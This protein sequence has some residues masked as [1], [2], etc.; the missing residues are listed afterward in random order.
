MAKHKVKGKTM[1]MQKL[2]LRLTRTQLFDRLVE[3]IGRW[4][5]DEAENS[6]NREALV[7]LQQ[8]CK[9]IK[10]TQAQ[11]LAD[12]QQL[13]EKGYV[14]PKKVPTVSLDHGRHV[15]I[16]PKYVTQFQA[17]LDQTALN[18]LYIDKVVGSKVVV[19]VGNP[20]TEPV[21][22]KHLISKLQIAVTEAH[23]A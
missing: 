7:A 22:I 23:A 13:R 1:A 19:S 3:R 4:I 11:L 12:V 18:N 6:P 16:K 8:R 21:T 20:A 15:W 10:D 5:A 9:T 17:V 14:P 2:E